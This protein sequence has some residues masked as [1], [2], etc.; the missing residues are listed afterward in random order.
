MSY[1]YFLEE[2]NYQSYLA[3]QELLDNLSVIS[4]KYN[5]I[6]TEQN[7]DIITE[8]VKQTVMTY[9]NKVIS[10]IQA[11]WNKFKTF[12]DD[13]KFDE[14]K[15]KYGDYFDSNFILKINQEDFKIP[16]FNELNKLLELQMPSN[17]QSLLQSI[18]GNGIEDVNDY[19]KQHFSYLYDEKENNL[20]KVAEDKIFKTISNNKITK[21]ELKPYIDF[22]NS[23]NEKANKLSNDIKGI[24]NAARNAQNIISRPTTES[25]GLEETMEYY[26]SEADENDDKKED[27][28]PTFSSGTSNSDKENNSSTDNENSKNVSKTVTV[29][30]KA[31]TSVLSVKLSMLRKVEKTCYSIVRNFGILASKE[32]G[33]KNTT[34]NKKEESSSGEVNQVK[35]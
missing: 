19:I 20:S 27:N 13:K 8:D 6:V 33:N 29:H 11:A 3:E 22:L 34:D 32:L 23:Y 28:K 7:Y 30:F 26:F 21:N 18:A 2:L 35:I 12:I 17:L 4:V 9:I 5:G 24:N 15:K 10:S 14:L 31:C 1:E 16:D 25:F